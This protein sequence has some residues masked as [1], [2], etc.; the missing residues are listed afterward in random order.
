[1]EYNSEIEIDTEKNR[2]FHIL[3]HKVTKI[4]LLIH[5]VAIVVIS[6]VIIQS[7]Y[8][9]FDKDELIEI[10]ITL[11]LIDSILNIL[12]VIIYDEKNLSNSMLSMMN[13]IIG[14]IIMIMMIYK[15]KKI[16]TN[17]YGI[18][19]FILEL[20]IPGSIFMLMFCVSVCSNI[21]S[22]CS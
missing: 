17:S 15:S 16:L 22:C 18:M 3:N 14:F 9:S 2:Y 10:I 4:L 12:I 8:I 11:C 5:S 21:C 13:G 19:L 6:S 20:I 1:M 7:K